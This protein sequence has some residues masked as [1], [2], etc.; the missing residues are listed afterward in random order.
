MDYIY[1]VIKKTRK[2]LNRNI[3]MNYLSICVL[4]GIAVMFLCLLLGLI[5]P[6]YYAPFIGT[7]ALIISVIVGIIIGV[8]KGSSEYETA[9]Y[10]DSLGFREKIITALENS[11]SNKEI[12][13]LQRNDAERT[14]RGNIAGVYVKWK[15]PWI[16]MAVIMVMLI[17]TVIALNTVTP[18]KLKAEETHLA[19]VEAK[20]AAKET[21]KLLEAL[22]DIDKNQLSPEEL[23]KLSS[24]LETLELS[25]NEMEK[26]DSKEALKKAQDRYDY[27]LGD[28]KSELE[29]MT[30]GKDPQTSAK[31]KSA[32]EIA[33]NQQK[34][35]SLKA[36]NQ[37]PDENQNGNQNQN[38]DQSGSG[39]QNQ[40][41]DQNGNGNQNQNG[42]QNGGGDQN[43]NGDQNGSGNQSGD[44]NQSGSGGQDGGSSQGGAGGQNGQGAGH[45]NGSSETQVEHNHEYVSV[46]ENV[47]GKYGDNSNSEYTRQQN[48]LAWEGKKV[49][50]NTVIND[51]KNA[52]ND[53]IEKGKYPGAM[54]GV[55]RDYFTELGD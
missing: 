27:K 26:A 49:P 50:Y 43:Q 37:D 1:S 10:I 25:K 17:L 34:S 9:L 44:G 48:G 41:G 12:H 16:R 11:K 38:G 36:Q 8:L 18:A 33:Q 54:S 31:I 7:G 53:G 3:M 45:G 13:I 47:S 30:E 20:K 55:I 6:I 40:K 21:D 52:A 51:Y 39:N 32:Q 24:M 46:N 19:K 15:I 35:E 23:K 42:D 28:V 14:L 2:K 5:F 4:I 29:K 22:K